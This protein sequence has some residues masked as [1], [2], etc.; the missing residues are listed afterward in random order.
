MT[1]RVESNH[2]RDG[3]NSERS[4]VRGGNNF[5]SRFF[6]F[7]FDLKNPGFPKIKSNDGDF[8]DG[9][10]T[11]K[12]L[13]FENILIDKCEQRRPCA[14]VVVVIVDGHAV[15]SFALQREETNTLHCLTHSTCF[16]N[17]FKLVLWGVGWWVPACAVHL[18]RDPVV[19][20]RYESVDVI[21]PQL[22]HHGRQLSVTLSHDTT[23]RPCSRSRGG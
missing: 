7:F 21:V 10:L 22:L 6:F 5:P 12:S 9:A 20:S 17:I 16:L 11:Q 2:R 18:Q 15:S 4:C 13:L 19:F 8:C 1:G 3:A 14:I 23:A